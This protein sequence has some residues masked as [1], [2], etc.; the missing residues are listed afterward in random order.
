MILEKN[1]KFLMLAIFICLFDQI[2]KYFAV[3]YLQNHQEIHITSQ[4]SFFLLYNESTVFSDVQ[5]HQWPFEITLYQFKVFY[6]TSISLLMALVLWLNKTDLKEL[7]KAAVFV[8]I[9]MLFLLAGGLGNVLD[10]AFRPQGVVDFIKIN[11]GAISPVMNL[12][13]CMIYFGQLFIIP[14]IFYIGF[15]LIEKHILKKIKF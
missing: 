5:L 13:D 6:V 7:G 8:R 10:Q 9:G 11:Q 1:P 2:T 4:L 14:S 3:I 15:L 12:A